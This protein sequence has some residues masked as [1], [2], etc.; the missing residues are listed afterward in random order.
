MQGRF[1]HGLCPCFLSP[2]CNLCSKKPS[3]LPRSSS[4]ARAHPVPAVRCTVHRPSLC[5]APRPLSSSPQRAVPLPSSIVHLIVEPWGVTDQRPYS[6]AGVRSIT[7][8]H[9]NDQY[10][11]VYIARFQCFFFISRTPPILPPF[12]RITART[13][14]VNLL[15]CSMAAVEGGF[16]RG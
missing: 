7:Q 14:T 9:Q 5:A 13:Q 15:L 10:I 16:V 1:S 8:S 12:A 6:R 11:Q 3:L 2:S 4:S